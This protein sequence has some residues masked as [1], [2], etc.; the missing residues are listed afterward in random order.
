MGRRIDALAI[1]GPVL[2][3][4]EF[5]VAGAEFSAVDTDQ[6]AEYALDLKNFHER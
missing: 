2:F 3:V 4:P 6:V 1:I 5:K